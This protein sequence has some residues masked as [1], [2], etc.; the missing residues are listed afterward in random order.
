MGFKQQ[1]STHLHEDM[2]EKRGR[3]TDEAKVLVAHPFVTIADGQRITHNKEGNNAQAEVPKVFD[4]NVC[5]VFR[6][7]RASLKHAKSSLIGRD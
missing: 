1:S 5:C 2:R 3:K 6:P 7:N 4:E